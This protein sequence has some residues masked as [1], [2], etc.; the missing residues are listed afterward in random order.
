[1][2]QHLLNE[3]LAALTN[4][5]GTTLYDMVLQKLWS[6]DVRHSHHCASILDR[7]P[8]LSNLLSEQSPWQ[9]EGTSPRSL[10]HF[11]LYLLIT[12]QNC[13]LGW[14]QLNWHFWVCSRKIF[15]L[16]E[17]QMRLRAAVL[18][19]EPNNTKPPHQ[20]LAVAI[21]NCPKIK[22]QIKHVGTQI[23]H[24]RMLWTYSL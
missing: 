19:W 21:G 9:L 5:H 20:V 8:D 4:T 16:N 14:L 15:F 7:M 23:Q 13:M 3:I 12:F 6:C 22:V 1:M 24:K 17:F 10:L 2:D 18:L 11:P